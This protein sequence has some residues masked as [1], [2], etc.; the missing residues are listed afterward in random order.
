MVDTL[1]VFYDLTCLYCA[2]WGAFVNVLFQD[3][4][5]GQN[6]LAV[7]WH[8]LKDSLLKYSPIQIILNPLWLF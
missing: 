3:A 7:W 1:P 5:N 6:A 2:F 8:A 4:C